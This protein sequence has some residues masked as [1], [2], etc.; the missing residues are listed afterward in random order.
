MK[1]NARVVGQGTKISE[2]F[3][4][5]KTVTSML[6]CSLLKTNSSKWHDVTTVTF[7]YTQKCHCTAA[8]VWNMTNW[9]LIQEND[10]LD[11]AYWKASYVA[12]CDL[13]TDLITIMVYQVYCL[14]INQWRMV[15]TFLGIWIQGKR[16]R[17][18]NQ[19]AHTL[20]VELSA[21]CGFSPL[22]NVR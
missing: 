10:W 22:H 19:V 4:W 17:K 3:V 1:S 16:R 15:C 5:Y 9:W 14:Y 18:W 2:P 12:S 20:T 21:N 13:I 6:M 8:N 7:I 11:V